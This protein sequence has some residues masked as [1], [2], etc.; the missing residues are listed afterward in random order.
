MEDEKVGRYEGGEGTCL[1]QG[2][3]IPEAEM[4]MRTLQEL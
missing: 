4:S 1:A 2:P 3:K